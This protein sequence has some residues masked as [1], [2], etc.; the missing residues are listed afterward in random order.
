MSNTFHLELPDE[1]VVEISRNNISVLKLDIVV[2]DIMLGEAQDGFNVADRAQQEQWLERYAEMLTQRAIGGYVFSI[3]D[4]FLVTQL[5]NKMVREMKKKL[6]G[7]GS[8]SGLTDTHPPHSHPPSST[9]S[10]QTS[11]ES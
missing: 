3:S 6:G 5:T 8:S 7:L 1:T 4:A 11:P 2:L 10:E 9:S